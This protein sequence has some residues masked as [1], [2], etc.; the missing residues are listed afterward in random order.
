[1]HRLLLF[2]LVAIFSACQ[3][4][5]ESAS[6][7]HEM[8]SAWLATVWGLDWPSV[9]GTSPAVIAK[10]KKELEDML[11]GLKSAGLNAVSFQVRSMADAMYRSSYEPWSRFLTGTRGVAPEDASWDPL[12]FCVEQCHK[13]GME[14][15]AWV[16]PFR[17]STGALPSTASD[18][19]MIESGWIISYRKKGKKGAVSGSSILDP[20]NPAARAHIINVC[21]EIVTKYDIDGLMFDDYFYPEGL[22]LGRGYDFDEWTRAGSGLSQ[23]DWRRNNVRMLIRDVYSMIQQTK[24]YVK[25]GIS[26]AGVGGGNGVS[27]GRYGLPVCYGGSDWMYDGIYCDP[28]AW[29]ADGSVDYISPQIYWPRD[30]KSNPYGPIAK[31]WAEVAGHFGRHFYSSLSPAKFSSSENEV[32]PCAEGGGQID[33]NRIVSIDLSPGSVFYSA[34]HIAGKDSQA[35]NRYLGSNH[36]RTRALTPPMPWKAADEPGMIAGVRKSE[37]RLEWG[38]IDGMRYVAY[39]VPENVTASDAESESY[40]G[41][42]AEYIIDVTYEPEISLPE[43]RRSGY[44]YAVAPFDRYSNEWPATFL[45]APDASTDAI[46]HHGPLSDDNVGESGLPDIVDFV[47]VAI[48]EDDV[49]MGEP[50][51]LTNPLRV[52]LGVRAQTARMFDMTGTLVATSRESEHIDAPCPGEFVVRMIDCSGISSTIKVMIGDDGVAIFNR[53]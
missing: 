24:P 25:F 28:L 40:P 16:N 5:G 9:S 29:L 3:S 50:E 34:K 44:W 49:A 20:G 15:H 6:P 36:F 10:Q 4:L 46:E 8:R 18:K 51:A 32:D 7:K 31:W 2:T 30:S 27:A 19:Q 43:N 45:D 38:A 23:A 1:M 26:P 42:K 39:A 33:L 14:C 41:L 22:P 21:R 17:F 37:D 48:A 12:S 13:R 11:D 47:D 52:S 35:F 53:K